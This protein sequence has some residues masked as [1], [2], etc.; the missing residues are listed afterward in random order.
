[1][2]LILPF[3]FYN[4]GMNNETKF[5]FLSAANQENIQS[6]QIIDDI[7]QTYNSINATIIMRPAPFRCQ[8]DE[9]SRHI[10][11][12]DNDCKYV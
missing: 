3:L 7:D 6:P 4:K 5:D 9:T 2:P 12:E 8:I 11:Q 1:M 10:L